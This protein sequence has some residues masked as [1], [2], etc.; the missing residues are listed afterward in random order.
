MPDDAKVA[1]WYNTMQLACACM[2]HMY[3]P[4]HMHADNLPMALP[5]DMMY[6]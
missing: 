3:G 1:V 6:S 2:L 5:K 4:L